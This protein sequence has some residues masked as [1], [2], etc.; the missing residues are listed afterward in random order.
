MQKLVLAVL[1]VIVVVLSLVVPSLSA[2]RNK[3][4]PGG[5][6]NTAADEG[7]S[8]WS[9]G[10][11][12]FK[13]ERTC[14]KGVKQGVRSGDTCQ[15]KERSFPCKVKCSAAANSCQYKPVRQAARDAQCDPTTGKLTLTLPLIRGDATT[16]PATKVVQ[17]NCEGQRRGGR[18]RATREAKNPG[19]RH[20]S[21]RLDAAGDG[22]G[23]TESPVAPGTGGRRQQKKCKYSKSQWSPCNTGTNQRTKTLTLKPGSDPTCQA[24]K[25]VTKKCRHQ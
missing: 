23:S 15:L 22:A 2:R 11:C 8:E 10:P 9:F 7:C 14:G 12:V 25:T 24:T 21:G 3:Q 18:S 20:R 6:P 1:V 13:N 4:R 5:R 19:G 17:K 16:C